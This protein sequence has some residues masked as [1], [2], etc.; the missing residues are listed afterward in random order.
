MSVGVSCAE[1][2]VWISHTVVLGTVIFSSVPPASLKATCIVAQ[3]FLLLVVIL[4]A[5]ETCT[6]PGSE[7]VRDVGILQLIYLMD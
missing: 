7:S 5:R 4:V 1:Q 2:S 6:R 3:S